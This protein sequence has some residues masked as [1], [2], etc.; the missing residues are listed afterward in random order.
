M[1]TAKLR[2]EIVVEP[3]GNLFESADAVLRLTGTGK[4]VVFLV[5]QADEIGRAHV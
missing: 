1:M 4:L 5:E 3:L 2:F